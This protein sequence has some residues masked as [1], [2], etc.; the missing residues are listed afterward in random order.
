MISGWQAVAQQCLVSRC[1]VLQYCTIDCLTMPLCPARILQP[2]SV[3]SGHLTAALLPAALNHYTSYY[4]Q[5]CPMA[6]S[7]DKTCVHNEDPD[8]VPLGP[9]AESTWLNVA[10]QGFR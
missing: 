5:D 6:D 9:R 7:I 2:A 10:P 4:I 1:L 3:L 8:G